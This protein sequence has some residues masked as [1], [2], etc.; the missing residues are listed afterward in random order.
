M[1]KLICC[2]AVIMLGG[3]IGFT[4]SNGYHKRIKELACCELLFSR[5]KICLSASQMPTKALF[6]DLSE[7]QGL[8]L[9]PFVEKTGKAL[10]ENPDFPTIWRREIEASRPLLALK[11]DDYRPILSLCD[12]IGSCDTAGVLEGIELAGSLL[13]QA[14]ADAQC[15]YEKNGKLARSVGVLSGIAAAILVF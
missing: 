14:Q 15:E 11:T 6:L 7:Q 3:F 1:L 12:L 9:L 8:K 2:A 10:S 4:K 5:M 13:K